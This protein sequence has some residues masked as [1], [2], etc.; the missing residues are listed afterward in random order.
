M[1]DSPQTYQNHVR[2]HAPFHYVMLPLA[3]INLIWAIVNLVRHPEGSTIQGLLVAFLLAWIGFLARGNALRAQD[4]IIR[5]EEQLRYQRVL[6]PEMAKRASALSSR[7]IIALRFASDEELA[8]LIQ[9][10][11]ENKFANT[12]EIKQAIQNWRGDYLRV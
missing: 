8:G 2:Y 12:K 4:R 10:T 11:L 3:T 1:P 5:L 7:Q 6:S 9:Q